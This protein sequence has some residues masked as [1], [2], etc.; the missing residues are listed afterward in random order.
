ML[1]ILIVEDEDFERTALKFLINKYFAEEVYVV[2]EASNGKE[3]LDKALIFK[4][5]IVLMDIN[6]PIMDGLIASERLKQENKDLDIIILTAYN[7]FEY[8]KKAI[9][10]G[11]SDYLLKPFSD[12]DFI[13]SI[14]KIIN[15][16]KVRNK[17]LLKQQ[18]LSD[19]YN[20]A[21]PFIEK[22]LITKIAYGDQSSVV[23]IEENLKLLGIKSRNTFCV[24]IG[25][26][27]SYSFKED[28]VQLIKNILSYLSTEVIG[29][30][31]LGDLV[32]FVFDEKTEDIA[33]G[34]RMQDILRRIRAHFKENA[35]IDV[36]IEIGPTTKEIFRYNYSYSQA[37]S[38]FRI[39]TQN[40]II[41]DPCYECLKSLNIND[42]ENIISGKIINEDLD[43]AITEA[44]KLTEKIFSSSKDMDLNDLKT[45]I[46]Q[47][48][49]KI[50]SNI[51]DFINNE[52][53]EEVSQRIHKEIKNLNNLS[54]VSNYLN[55]FIKGL[56]E[57]IS[58]YKN[59]NNLG[60]VIDAKRFIDENYNK[61]I[62]LEDVAKH[63]CI[64]TYYFSRIFK[65][66]EG[67]NYIQY[68]TKVRME[69]AKELII[70]DKLTIKEIA[71]EVGFMDQN[72]FSRAF[73]KY[74][75]ESPREF[76]L[77]HKK[78]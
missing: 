21:I 55:I 6:M 61:D 76:S 33:L 7:E 59:T 37:K 48:I 26:Q 52:E 53:N 39:A 68:L 30:R 44:N 38:V 34:N 43:G 64:S 57:E 75:R 46:Y 3:A 65:K 60:I 2:G 9:K 23:E 18:N 4:P 24:L 1:K 54:D 56:I 11:V 71:I 62:R 70:E 78:Y 29:A 10:C 73:K 40:P 66:F 35:N 5:H 36:G 27:S 72:Y 58:E 74:T 15:V 41:E 49:L 20:K 42:K 47:I 31:F 69:K 12:K 17:E 63:V 14:S 28:S 16:I 45:S 67:V 8:A 51:L 77:K 25:N 19:N 50:R 22:E 32:F 13:T